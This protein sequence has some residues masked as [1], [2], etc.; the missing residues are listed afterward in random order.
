MKF[1]KKIHQLKKANNN[2]ASKAIVIL[3]I[4]AIIFLCGN[5][6][7]MAQTVSKSSSNTSYSNSNSDN[8]GG[9]V[10]ISSSSSSDSYSFSAKHSGA[11]DSELKDLITKE[12][13][14]NNLTTS[15]GR[16][17][18]NVNSGD[19]MVYEIEL[20][21]GRLTIDVDKTIASPSLVKKIESLGKMARTVI[22]GKTEASQKAA[23][24]Q[25]E[26]DR[27]KREADRMQRE[28]ER[29]KREEARI[30]QHVDRMKIQNTARYQAD[31]KRFNE[32]AKRLA[33]EAS[34]MDTKARHLG[35]VSN[36]V[37]TLLK[38][39]RTFSSYYNSFEGLPIVAK[40][41][42]STYRIWPFTK[43]L[44]FELRK[45][46]APAKSFGSPHFAAGVLLTIKSLNGCPSTLIAAV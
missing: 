28:A 9:N 27:L 22:T 24:L 20:R 11:K 12:M 16:S 5:Q 25:R 23:R 2:F 35:G 13:G 42:P 10:S 30:Q 32:E 41:P 36:T 31:A 29:M 3:F 18:W 21:K 17:Q 8:K 1:S 26:A 38:Q 33:S 7:G 46:A 6:L 19:E 14:T 43:S 39:E 45:I 15:N 44:A 34:E 40:I 4:N 37:R